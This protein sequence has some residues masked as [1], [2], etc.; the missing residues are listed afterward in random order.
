[1]RS[2]ETKQIMGEIFDGYLTETYKHSDEENFS[3]LRARANAAWEFLANHPKE[4]ICVVTHGL[5][6][7]ILFCAAV[8]GPNFS[9]RDLQ[10][11][12]RSAETDN[13]GVSHFILQDDIFSKVPRKKWIL[14]NWNDS[15]HLG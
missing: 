15:A 8:H 9:G 1:M 4:N 10:D 13:T 5:F 14:K 11:F 7:R 6:L 12:F 2:E 3:Q